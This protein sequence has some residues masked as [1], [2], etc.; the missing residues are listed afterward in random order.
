LTSAGAGVGDELKLDRAQRAVKFTLRLRSIVPVDH[1]DLV[2]NGRVVKSF[3]GRTPIDHG[4]F[5]GSIDLAASGWCLARASTDQSRYPVLDNY[6]YAT[7]SPVYVT[8]A[9]RAPRSPEDARY[10]AAWIDR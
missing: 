8:I 1:V 5:S 2:C 4:E 10:F 3:A 7:T 9:G 6:A